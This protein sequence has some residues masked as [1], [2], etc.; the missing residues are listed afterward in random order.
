MFAIGSGYFAQFRA[1]LPASRT[2]LF[3]KACLRTS[4]VSCTHHDAAACTGV[5][6][7]QNNNDSRISVTGIFVGTKK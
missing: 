3:L 6:V 4:D 2:F 7:V 5:T 1:R